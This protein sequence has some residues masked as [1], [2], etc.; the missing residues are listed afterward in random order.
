MLY[1][2]RVGKKSFSH[3]KWPIPI[4]FSQ[5]Y[6]I[7]RTKILILQYDWLER[8][9]KKLFASVEKENSVTD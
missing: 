2:E 7:L 9:E 3:H 6:G 8:F 4:N 1:L 5:I